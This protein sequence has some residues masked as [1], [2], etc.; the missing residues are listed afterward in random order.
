M[1]QVLARVPESLIELA[2][3]VDPVAVS[4][5]DPSRTAIPVRPFAVPIGPIRVELC[6]VL[7][8]DQLLLSQPKSNI[9]IFPHAELLRP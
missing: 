6:I 3:C 2:D 9:G 5:I 8:K 7:T 1:I 4:P